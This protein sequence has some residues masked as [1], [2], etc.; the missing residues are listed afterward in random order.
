LFTDTRSHS[1]IPNEAAAVEPAH[2]FLTFEWGNA[3]VTTPLTRT[4][5]GFGRR[6]ANA[7]IALRRGLGNLVPS[8]DD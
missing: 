7:A 6:D 5:L 8:T 3:I 2:R 4:R 1:L